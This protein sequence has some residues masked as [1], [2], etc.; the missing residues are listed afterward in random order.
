MVKPQLGLNSDTI[1]ENRT[2]GNRPELQ[3]L[4]YHLNKDIHDGVGDHVIITQHL[5]EEDP[6]K[7]SMRTPKNMLSAYLRL[8]D[9]EN[10][11][12][13]IPAQARIKEDIDQLIDETY[14][15]IVSLRGISLPEMM[16]SGRWAQ[17][18]GR[19]SGHGGKRKKISTFDAPWVNPSVA[20]LDTRYGKRS[21][22]IWHIKN[23]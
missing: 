22:Q 23:E 12:D 19:R 17:I 8:F 6:L 16:Y 13:G 3:P 21:K 9:P 2:I 15:R 4:D 11:K 20:H 18:V 14:L 7:F 10:E 5:A 1:Y